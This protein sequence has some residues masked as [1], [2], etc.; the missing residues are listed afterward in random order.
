MRDNW[1]ACRRGGAWTIWE[2]LAAGAH[3]NGSLC[4]AW[5]TTP[6]RWFHERVLGVRREEA[7]NPLR[8]VV[9]P[10]S[11]LEWAEGSVP[12]PLGSVRVAWR[13]HADRLDISVAAP[14][15][16][17]VTILPGASFAGLRV[18]ATTTAFGPTA[19]SPAAKAAAMERR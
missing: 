2:T 19:N 13:R 8:M 15:R 4:H 18:V 12:H 3:G 1:S 14:E 9:A 16:V 10:D 5:S 7:G 6:I 11:A 17:M